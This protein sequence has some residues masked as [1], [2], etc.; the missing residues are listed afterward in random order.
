VRENHSWSVFCPRPVPVIWLVLAGLPACC[1][2]HIVLA[3]W[4][5]GDPGGDGPLQLCS[6]GKS[7]CAADGTQDT[8]RFNLSNTTRLALPDC[9]FGIRRIVILDAESQD[10][11]ADVECAARPPTAPSPGGRLPTTVPGGGAQ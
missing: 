4:P 9:P 5:S 1:S 3:R 8:S 6:A 11:Y 10:A 7:A 2:H